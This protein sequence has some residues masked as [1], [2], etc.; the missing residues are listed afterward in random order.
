MNKKQEVLRKCL[1]MRKH[2][3]WGTWAGLVSASNRRD[4]AWQVGKVWTSS[5]ISQHQKRQVGEGLQIST[6]FCHQTN[7]DV[8]WA[9]CTSHWGCLS[10]DWHGPNLQKQIS[11]R[12]EQ[13]LTIDDDSVDKVDSLASPVQVNLG[14]IVFAWRGVCVARRGSGGDTSVPKMSGLGHHDIIV[15]RKTTV[16]KIE[17]MNP[18]EV[19]IESLGT[20]SALVLKRPP[21]S[22][23]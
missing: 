13:C 12:R 20:C 14:P 22:K 9:G 2:F 10:R 19:D 18:Y 23:T 8:Y 7:L 21:S 4:R 16:P 15:Q 5:R 1:K 11:M 3:T 17:L 6:I